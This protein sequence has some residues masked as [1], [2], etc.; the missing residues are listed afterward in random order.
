MVVP[1]EKGWVAGKRPPGVQDDGVPFP[2]LHESTKKKSVKWDSESETEPEGLLRVKIPGSPSTAS[3]NLSP[4][5]HF[6]HHSP[7]S[8][9]YFQALILAC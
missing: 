9:L 5:H 2:V 1:G 7:G 3:P 6:A 4:Y 8:I